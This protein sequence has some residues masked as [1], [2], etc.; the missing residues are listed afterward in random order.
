MSKLPPVELVCRSQLEK[1][2]AN[3]KWTI[4]YSILQSPFGSMLL[5]T[6]PLGI[7]SISLT[8]TK[9][10]SSLEQELAKQWKGFSVKRS[11][12]PADELGERI[13][14]K[15]SEKEC[16]R[17]QLFAFAT[18]F[19]FQVWKALLDIPFGQTSNYGHI[20][21]RIG[22]PS[23]SRAVGTAVGSNPIALLIPCHRVIRGDGKCGNY[24][25]GSD[26]KRQILQWENS[27]LR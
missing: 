6:C 3:S 24:R 21:Q 12:R 27:Q 25:W 8:D 23:A 15:D 20:A 16:E 14:P 2:S 10:V 9:E 17:L 18:N 5:A 19:Q 13:F 7:C 26:L 1:S 11:N 4:E 22:T